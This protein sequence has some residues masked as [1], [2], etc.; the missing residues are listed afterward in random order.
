MTIL[1]FLKTLFHTYKLKKPNEETQGALEEK[2]P[3]TYE[4][5]EEFLDSIVR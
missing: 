3:E 1:K 2:N 5:I 4:S